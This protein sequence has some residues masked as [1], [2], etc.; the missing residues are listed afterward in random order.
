MLCLS[1]DAEV[2]E[3]ALRVATPFKHAQFVQAS[4]AARAAEHCINARVMHTSSGTEQAHRVRFMAN[5]HNKGSTAA[6]LRALGRY[7]RSAA[8]LPSAEEEKLQH[9]ER[10]P[11]WSVHRARESIDVERHRTLSS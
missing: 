9:T 5:L 2:V 1:R 11:P 8:T 4:S 6:L 7:S 10:L 3:P